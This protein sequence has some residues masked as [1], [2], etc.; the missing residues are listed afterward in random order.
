MMSCIVNISFY[1]RKMSKKFFWK[2]IYFYAVIII[3]Y[4]FILVNGGKI[5]QL[6]VCGQ[7]SKNPQR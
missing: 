3:L 5:N 1:K 4:S 2:Q 6:K 7:S